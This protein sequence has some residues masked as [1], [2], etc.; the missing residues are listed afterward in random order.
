MDYGARVYDNANMQRWLTQDPLAELNYSQSPYAFA[1]NNPVNFVDPDGRDVVIHYKNS[2]GGSQQY[3][4]RGE[5]RGK[6]PAR[7]V[8]QF[9]D[10]Y[11]Y[12]TSN[13]GGDVLRAVAT[14]PNITIP[15]YE[16]EYNSKFAYGHVWWN[17]NLGLE[18]TTGNV[19]SPATILEH[20]M[21]HAASYYQ[22][23]EAHYDRTRPGSDAKYGNL[24]ESRVIRGSESKTARVNGEIRSGVYTRSDHK[25]SHVI[26]TGGPTSTDV[27]REK[28]KQFQQELY[29][30]TFD[31]GW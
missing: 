6:H 7:F 22:D 13:G 19:L 17:P 30:K 25:G 18:T 20:E 15:L 8:N 27:H 31:A 10:A 29:G 28:S 5:D 23:K 9:L 16:A 24:E 1:L 14:N 11:R 26:V 3:V 12:N 4:Y 2:R 21:D